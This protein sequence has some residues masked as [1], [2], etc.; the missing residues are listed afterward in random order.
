M[1]SSASGLKGELPVIAVNNPIQFIR[2]AFGSVAAT[3]PV[4]AALWELPRALLNFVKRS[5]P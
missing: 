4:L 2:G 1:R 3:N 5:L